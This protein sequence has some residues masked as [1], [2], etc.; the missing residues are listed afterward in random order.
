[1]RADVVLL[2]ALALAGC[3]GPSGEAVSRGAGAADGT[4]EA[5]HG[6]IA[7]SV[8]VQVHTDTVRLRLHVT[9]T[10]TRP[11]D[12]TF[13]TSQRYDFVVATDTGE[14]VWRWSD[15]MMFAQVISEVALAPGETWDFEAAWEPGNRAGLFQ[16]LGEVTASEHDVRQRMTFE[17]P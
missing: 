3:A 13:P 16:V 9:N 1:M 10:G 14:R 12:F 17:L 4:E 7:A 5:M 11:I 2:T 6:D 8:Q 15:E